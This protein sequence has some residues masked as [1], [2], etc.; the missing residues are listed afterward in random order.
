VIEPVLSDDA[1][2]AD[3]ESAGRDGSHTVHLWWLGQSG[4][5]IQHDGVRLLIDPYL[6]DS[7]TRKYAGSAKPHVRI[8]RRVIDPARLPPVNCVLS[9]HNHTDHLDAE[10]LSAVL[11]KSPNLLMCV[12]AANVDFVR[13]RLGAALREDR[14]CPIDESDGMEFGDDI[15][16]DVVPA[17]H[18]EGDGVERDAE[19]RPRCV[20]YVIRVGNYTIYHSGDGVVFDG[21]AGLD[22]LARVD[23]AILPINGKVGNMGGADAAR[24]AKD[25]DARIAV[26]CHYDLFEFNTA[27]PEEEF[28]PTCQ[29]LRQAY[30]VLG[31]GERLTLGR[32]GP[33]ASELELAW[34]VGKS[35][36]V[37]LATVYEDGSKPPE[38]K[39]LFGEIV[40]ADSGNIVVLHGE[41]ERLSLPPTPDLFHRARPGSYRLRS[42]GKTIESPDLLT[43][44]TVT[45]HRDGGAG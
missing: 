25:I 21:Q 11:A 27:D 23:V 30:R 37:G 8:S 20:G 22:R 33:G 3:I 41:D 15:T 6:S 5:L 1:L 43:T 24:L 19:G 32:V 44:W 4:Y 13:Q 26:P 7:L 18:G 34:L 28:V 38:Q 16:I 42:T 10:T 17:A 29:R 36:L 9:T 2:L 14:L 45:K 12:G 40:S 35:V 31:L 39:Q